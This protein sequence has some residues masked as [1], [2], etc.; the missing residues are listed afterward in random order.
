MV[1]R[2]H[3]LKQKMPSGIF[4]F[5]ERATGLEPVNLFLG[6]EAFYQLNYARGELRLYVIFPYCQP[7]MFRF[8]FFFAK[9]YLKK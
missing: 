2:G 6:K 8:P 3:C 1:A 5:S 9:N 4:L 7:F